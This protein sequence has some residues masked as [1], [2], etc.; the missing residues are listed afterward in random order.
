MTHPVKGIDH[1]FSLVADLDA[2]AG[3]FAALG[4][5]LSPRGM[6]SE[7]KGSA[8]YTIMF[9]DDY[10]ELLGLLRPTP[11][12]TARYKTLEDQGE[13]L[14]AIAC[15]IDDARAAEVALGELGIATQNLS[16]FERPVDLPDGSKGVAAFSTLSFAPEEVPLGTMFMCQHRSRDTVWLPDLLDHPN[17]ARGLAGI[18]ARSDTPEADAKAFAR[19]WAD[20]AVQPTE[21]GA[22]VSTGSNSAPLTLL[23]PDAFNQRY[24]G[25]DTNALP[26]GAFGVLQVNVGDEDTLLSV[27][28]RANV[29]TTRTSRGVAVGPAHAAGTI[30][31]FIPV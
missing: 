19:L 18:V 1:C 2:A 31:E 20:G 4:F 11:L 24:T 25:L 30:V 15:R 13:G 9:P 17:T 8:N 3:Q 14:H 21:G 10:Y 28:D 29:P 12:N 5:T 27:L 6:H 16:D 22:I 23:S 7:A 26:R